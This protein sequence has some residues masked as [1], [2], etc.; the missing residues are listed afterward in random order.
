M[1]TARSS[2][3]LALFML[4]LSQLCAQTSSPS[5]TPPPYQQQRY[6]EDWSYLSDPAR[7]TDWFD[8]V[9]YIP[10]NDGGWYLSLGGEARIRYEYF[11]KFA[12]G[13]GPQDNNG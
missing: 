2:F 7:H 1:K 9:K 11:S 6:D 12:F 10:L 13:A 3:L 5:P 4:S 8:R